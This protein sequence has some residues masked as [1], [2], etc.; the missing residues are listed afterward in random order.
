[1][2][3][4][5]I[6]VFAG[7]KPVEARFTLDEARLSAWMRQNV[8]GFDGPMTMAQF[9]GGQSN[10]TYQLTTPGAVYVLRRT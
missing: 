2:T 3:L 9:K 6:D 1:M 10:P 4:P 7:V 5:E 8:E